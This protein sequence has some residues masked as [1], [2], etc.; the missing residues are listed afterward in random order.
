MSALILDPALHSM[1]G[2]HYNAVLRLHSE[3]ARRSVEHRTLGAAN[4]DRDVTEGLG[5]EPTFSRSVYGRARWDYLEFEEAVRDTRRQLS[6]ALRWRWAGPGL[7]ILPCCDQVLAM[8][9]A[10][11]LRS[12]PF[13][14]F[15]H[16]LMWL[17]YAPHYKKAVDD[18][19]TADL[20]LEYKTAMAEL[21]AAMG[22]SRR[23]TVCCETEGMAALYRKL[24]GLTIEVVSGPNLIIQDRAQ[25]TAARRAEISVVCIG[26]AN[27]PKG[28]RLLPE[29][30]GRVLETRDDIRFFI[31]GTVAGTDSQENISVFR[32]LMAMGPKV[33]I[34]TDVLGQDQYRSWLH[35]ADV[36]LLPYDPS[37]YR[38]RGSGVFTEAT[39]LGIPTIATRGCGFASRAFAEGRA[40]EIAPYNSAGVAQAILQAADRLVP[41]AERARASAVEL[42]HNSRL[43]EVMDTVVEAAAAGKN[44]P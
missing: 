20:A 15:P 40:V 28:Y 11:Y 41:L 23:V 25:E 38:T 4:A 14:R 18:P 39:T 34:N 3:L 35:Q 9:V 37:V 7:V 22:S 31:H 6:K 10:R 26:Q 29:A 16:I 33:R 5:V 44:R 21:V 12:H 27:W 2:H 8:A 24:T 32:E 43:K 30:L 1:G 42:N 13:R 17:M 19:E 36:I